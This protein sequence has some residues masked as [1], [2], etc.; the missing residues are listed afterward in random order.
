MTDF[1]KIFTDGSGDNRK[2]DGGFGIVL[3][4]KEEEVYYQS[5]KYT[6]TSS[7]RMEIRGA[8]KALQLIEIKSL[9]VTLY[10]DNQYVVNSIAKGWAYKWE[11][12]N[13]KGEYEPGERQVFNIW[14]TLGKRTNYDLW[15][16]VL[17]EIRKFKHKPQFKWVKGHNGHEYNEICDILAG[18]A[19]KS[20]II[21][22]DSILLDLNKP[23]E[24]Q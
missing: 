16:Q 22:D 10:C 11:S 2:R 3:I 13:W 18:E 5:D 24:N 1:I 7:A 14:K 20:D 4:Y 21:I 23:V 17:A 9:P 6:N 12:E 8:L 15:I 19:R